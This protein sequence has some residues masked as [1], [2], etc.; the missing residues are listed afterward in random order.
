M[1]GDE[2][3]VL[4]TFPSQALMCGIFS[5]LLGLTILAILELAHPYQ[6]AVVVSDAPFK[7]AITRMNVMD[8]VAFSGVDEQA[9]FAWSAVPAPFPYTRAYSKSGPLFIR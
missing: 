8:K 5:S 4:E 3:A 2:T 9:P 7:F 1:L 6:G